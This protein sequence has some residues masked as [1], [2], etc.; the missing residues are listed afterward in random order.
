LLLLRCWRREGEKAKKRQSAK[1]LKHMKVFEE[2]PI[3]PR[4]QRLV[5][6]LFVAASLVRSFVRGPLS[7]ASFHSILSIE[8]VQSGYLEKSITT[9]ISSNERR[10]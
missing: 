8:S 2:E 3:V 10:E 1:A 7:C 5:R 9:T 6:L 4:F